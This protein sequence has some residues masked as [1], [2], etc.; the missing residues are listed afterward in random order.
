[1]YPALKVDWRVQ[2]PC[3]ALPV[4]VHVANTLGIPA[5]LASGRNYTKPALVVKSRRQ[6]VVAAVLELYRDP[7]TGPALLKSKLP[8]NYF[9]PQRKALQAILAANGY[10]LQT[11]SKSERVRSPTAN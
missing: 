7:P 8:E 5:L 10:T 6:S 1:M 4:A 9:A 3:C 11:N 2:L